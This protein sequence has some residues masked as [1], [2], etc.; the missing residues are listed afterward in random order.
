VGEIP[1]DGAEVPPERLF[2][3]RAD[4]D[5]GHLEAEIAKLL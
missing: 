4:N 1:A 5:G 2:V 3:A